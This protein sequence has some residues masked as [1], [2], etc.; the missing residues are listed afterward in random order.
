MQNCRTAKGVQLEVCVHPVY[1]SGEGEA[2]HLVIPSSCPWV[3][4]TNSAKVSKNVLHE[5]HDEYMHLSNL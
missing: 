4:S 5:Y 1:V 3:P 2:C